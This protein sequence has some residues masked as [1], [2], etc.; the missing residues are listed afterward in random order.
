MSASRRLFLMTAAAGAAGLAA[1]ALAQSPTLQKLSQESVI[2]QI[3]ARGKLRV[4]NGTF[5]PW[6]MYGKDGK[7]I[8][9][10]VDVAT[11]LAE[12]M[13]VD[14]ELI[15]TAWDGIIPALIAGKFDFIIG[16]LTITPKRAL[17]INFSMP[18]DY[19]ETLLVANKKKVPNLT[20]AAQFNSPDVTFAARRGATSGVTPQSAFPKAKVITFDDENAIEQELVNGSADATLVTTPT[21]A[22][23]ESKYPD[24]IRVIH[25]PLAR[26]ASGIGMRKGDPDAEA[27]LNAWITFYTNNNWLHDR[28][29]YWFDG[30]TWANLVDMGKK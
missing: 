6:A 12:D 18:Y 16:G 21:P 19:G 27:Y 9:F 2:E 14:I 26:S 4:A 25:E 5:V 17:T 24:V 11:K 29:A 7:L 8:G 13:G 30:R 20:T 1:P 22:L 10:E 15:P 28:H 23:I 3:K